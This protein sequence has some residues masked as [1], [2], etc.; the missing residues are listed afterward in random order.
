MLEGQIMERFGSI[1]SCSSATTSVIK[2]CS[3]LD[4][5]RWFGD[6]DERYDFQIHSSKG[7][8]IKAIDIPVA[9]ASTLWRNR[10]HQTL[11]LSKQSHCACSMQGIEKA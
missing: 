1:S 7:I 10:L 9:M 6:F 2:P 4:R 8:K 5:L 11:S 3:Y